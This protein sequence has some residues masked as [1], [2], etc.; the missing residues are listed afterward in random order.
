[1]DE[2]VKLTEE[3]IQ[4]K[5][6]HS[7]PDEIQK[8]MDF[9]E[10]YLKRSGIDCKRRVH[11][12]VPSVWALPQTNFAPVLLMTHIDVVDAPDNLFSPVIRD[13]KLYGR[14]SIDDK[15]AA[16]LSLVLLKEHFS[17]LK[18]E[19]K[20]QAELPFGILITGDEEVGGENGAKKALEEITA[21]FCI[22]LDGGGIDK[23]VI[24]EKG[25]LRL[26][27]TATGKTAHGARP[28]LGDN[29]IEKLIR[30]WLKIRPYFSHTSDDYWHKT[31]NF[32]IFH[33]GKAANQVP[34][35]AEGILDIRYTENDDLES[36]LEKWKQET[37][38]EIEILHWAPLF[39]G[40]K[41]RYLDILLKIS[42]ETKLGEEHGASD[43][44]YLADHGINGIVWGADG[45][46]SQHSEDEHINIDSMK[47]LYEV[48][49]RFMYEAEKI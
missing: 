32:S 49:D 20:G 4:F 15:Y 2:I 34:E 35:L 44:R 30:D 1:M 47:R 12:E 17:R 43:A 38:S 22:A 46:N 41:S 11:D 25:L 29:A 48:L 36:I 19:G 8:C 9:I 7:R 40:G 31:V 21:D 39:H 14:G 6:V 26:K 28:W 33:A 27:L 10:T 18:K 16:A 45:D 42:P 3:L 5:S 13:G 37:E 23:I 24:K